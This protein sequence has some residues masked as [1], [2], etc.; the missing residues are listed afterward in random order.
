MAGVV[1]GRQVRCARAAVLA[2]VRAASVRATPPADTAT[3]ENRR[4][5]QGGWQA[6]SGWSG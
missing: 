1:D 5:E 6:A 3:R 4:D 2:C